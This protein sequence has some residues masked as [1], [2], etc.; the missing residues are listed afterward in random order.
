M[1]IV[2]HQQNFAVLHGVG[3]RT[4]STKFKPQ[5]IAACRILARLVVSMARNHGFNHNILHRWLRELPD[6]TPARLTQTT[7]K[8]VPA[9]IELPITKPIDS[10]NIVADIEDLEFQRGVLCL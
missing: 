10:A 6:R 5:L 1:H 3:R 7:P 4:Y 2:V 9:F 8:P